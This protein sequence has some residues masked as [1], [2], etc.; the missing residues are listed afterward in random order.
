MGN[1]LLS[2]S[3]TPSGT[4]DFRHSGRSAPVAIIGMGCRFPGGADSP[5]AYWRL[6]AAGRD[7]LADVPGDRWSAAKFYSPDQAAEG[8]GQV[9][10]GGFLAGPVDEFDAR[11]FG[12][13]PREAEFVDPQQRLL[14]EVAWEALEDAGVRLEQL[15]GTA[16]GV[17]IGGFTLDYGQIQFA[18]PGAGRG[19]LTGHTATGVVMTMLANRISHAFDFRGPSMSVD[20]AC[21]SS[22]VA[23]HLAC[24]SL[25]SGESSV[26]VAGGVNLMLTPNFTIA[27]SKGGFLSPTSRSRAFDA[28]AD[29]YVR[30]EGAGVVLLKLL[31]DALRD[32][33]NIHAV[34]RGTAVTQ[35]GHTNGIAVPNGESQKTA[36]KI[37]LREAG[38]AASSV[39]YVEAHGAGTP[40]GDPIEADAIGEVYGAGRAGADRC[41][42]GSV[43]TNIGHL[44]AAAGIAGLIKA[45]LCLKHN[46][47]PPHLNLVELNPQI[48][49]DRLGMRIPLAAEKLRGSDGT[50]RVAVN[51]FGFGGTNAH[52]I[53]EAAPT[54]SLNDGADPAASPAEQGVSTI[55]PLSARSHGALTELADRYRHLVEQG[56]ADLPALAGAL[57][58]QR[59]NHTQARL[60]LVTDSAYEAAEALRCFSA[61]DPHSALHACAA[62][63]SGSPL[64]FVFTGMGPQWW[65]MGR[66]LLTTNQVF[67]SAIERCDAAL[68][69]LSDWSLLEELSA[70]Q[71]SSR[72]DQT[73]ISQVANF[74]LQVALAEVW[75]SFG[76]VP[77]AIVGHS[78]GEIAAAYVAGALSWADAVRVIFHRARLQ[79][80]TTGQGELVSV[81]VS[82]AEALNLPAV[83]DG[84]LTLAA[85]NSPTSIVLVG[86]GAD[87]AEA[88]E[89]FGR[90]GVFCRFV[91][92][93]VPFHSPKMDPLGAELREVLA[94]LAPRIPALPLYS[95]VTGAKVTWAVHDAEYW[96]L[97]VRAPVRFNEAAAALVRDSMTS[98]LEIGP[99]PVLAHSLGEVLRGARRTGF[100]LPSLKRKAPDYEVMS[101]SLAELYVS[102]YEPDWTAFYARPAAPTALPS[103]P[104]QRERYWRE[105]DR[106]RRDRLGDTDHPLLGSRHSNPQPTWRRTLDGTRPGYLADHRVMGANLFPGAG[107]VEMAAAAAKAS[108]GTALC[109]LEN[110][111]FHAPLI[112][113][114]VGAP[115]LNTTVDRKSGKVEIHSSQ[116]DGAEWVLH[117]SAEVRPTV[118]AG[119]AVDLDAAQARCPEEWDADHCYRYFKAAGFDYG[120]EF[121]SID[122][123]WL[124]DREAVGRFN[125]ESVGRGDRSDLAVDPILLDGCFQMLLPLAATHGRFSL[126][127]MLPVGADQIV[128]RAD[129]IGELR[130]H[131]RV[132]EVTDSQMA[133]DVLLVDGAGVTVLEVRGL[134]V[135]SI[136]PVHTGAVSGRAAGDWLYELCWEPLSPEGDPVAELETP[137]AQD[138]NAP[139]D[140]VAP[141]RWLLLADGSGVAAQTARLLRESGHECVLAASGDG[142]ARLGPDRYLV[143]P[144]SAGDLSALLAAA[145]EDAAGPWRGIVHLWSCDTRAADGVNGDTTDAA[146]PDLSAAVRRGPS[147]L[148]A[149]VHALDTAKQAAPLWLVTSGAQPVTGQIDA[150]GLAQAPLWGMGRV[151]GQESSALSARLVDLDPS[152]LLADLGSFVRELRRKT[153]PEDNFAW[154]AGEQYTARLKAATE[155]EFSLPVVLRP[156]AG[157]LITGGLGALGL[158]FAKHL[159]RRGARR[160][161]LVGRTAL[162]PRDQWRALPAGDERRAQ[163][164]QVREIEALGAEVEFAWL[165]VAEP[166]A[167]R[168]YLDERAAQG[169]GAVR[170]VIHSAGSVNDQLLVEMDQDAL[171]AVLRPKVQGAWALHECFQDQP[172]DFFA[173]FSSV[174]SIV[175]TPGQGNYAAGNAYL[176]ALAHYRRGLGL[177]ALTVNWGPWD[178]GMIARLNLQDAYTRRGIELLSEQAGPALF[179]ELIGSPAV[180][181]V[182]VKAHWPT[183]IGQYPIVPRMVE[184]LAQQSA[185]HNRA[186]QQDAR[187]LLD[188]VRAAG[189]EQA[190][191]MVADQCAAEVAAVLRATPAETART[192]PLTELGLDS[193]IAV[194]LRV[195][196]EQRFG[197]AP[198]VVSLLQGITVQA[199]ARY[200]L[201]ELRAGWAVAA[202]APD[203]SDE[204]ERL[205]GTVDEYMIAQF[206]DS[207]EQPLNEG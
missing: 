6:L 205:L 101:H 58:H 21:S 161:I 89:H 105:D 163:I 195:R 129:A 185:E 135:R 176:D 140:V 24:R 52:A 57:A 46:L 103:Y 119:P 181:R 109:T 1:T 133:G 116:A 107:Y 30:G 182:V 200:I 93:N 37:A 202:G 96:W 73:A 184:H 23:V 83:R 9:R 56:Q 164:E 29:G 72:M 22:L 128:L 191:A 112:L 198:K 78:A 196:L 44:E 60:A 28:Q 3:D 50:T 4:I 166:G 16:T 194:E 85:V 167:L 47:V 207:V 11:F 92:G 172:L 160:L 122:C 149:L 206:L 42:M 88:V 38:V 51:S 197:F 74:A 168:G 95:T 64:V 76:I 65:G 14:L 98:F 179:D 141:G 145:A 20:T 125:P 118:S 99:N 174:S 70:D 102:G 136:D 187:G 144:D 192:V 121:Q 36:I 31:A 146:E 79:Q 2:E 178:T 80:A 62:E 189:P 34:I 94:G 61:G 111:G 84:R 10:R 19:N 48:D 162:P 180:Q 130:C 204:L 68:R 117:A 147:S 33:D 43:K 71:E 159:A 66:E 152:D 124:G 170:G 113:T 91:D 171:R 100:T 155:S 190:E 138:P 40:V 154:R 8:V 104:W 173:L 193:M 156:D 25:W 158:L 110:V 5:Q 114:L 150:H 90:E 32:G 35:D 106:A 81:A 97:N 26:A 87:L 183:V 63:P 75:A 139:H 59:T 55:I 157:Y 115:T 186:Q 153:Q 120:P 45:A 175:V 151:L 177:A 18:G 27:A 7:A 201:G 165:D 142:F 39:S 137:Q 69:P 131:A 143:R 203:L 86:D 199:I 188:R 77:D 17:F 134:R 169:R 82:E 49:L 12:I 132:T 41:P 13:S 126:G 108:Y 15:A 148:L 127:N 67:R 53:L 54:P 123:L